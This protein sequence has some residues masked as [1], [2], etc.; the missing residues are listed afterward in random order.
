VSIVAC[1]KRGVSLCGEK[2]YRIGTVRSE[3][4]DQWFGAILF[5]GGVVQVE[6]AVVVKTVVQTRPN[7]ANVQKVCREDKMSQ[8]FFQR[9]PVEMTNYNF[10]NLLDGKRYI[11]LCK[12]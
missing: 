3:K 2:K 6:E 8:H 5:P 7:I 4:E 11:Y 9:F 1:N 10:A 12:L